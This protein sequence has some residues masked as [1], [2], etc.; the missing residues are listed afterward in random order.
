MILRRRNNN[1]ISFAVES[2]SARCGDDGQ[3]QRL[4]AF[5]RNLKDAV[6]FKVGDEDCSLGINGHRHWHTDT[7]SV[8]GQL[9]WLSVITE[10]IYLPSRCVSDQNFAIF[11]KGDTPGGVERCAELLRRF[12]EVMEFSVAALP[13]SRQPQINYGDLSIVRAD[14]SERIVH[15]VCGCRQSS[16]TNGGN[17]DHRRTTKSK[18]INLRTNTSQKR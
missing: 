10:S 15:S 12:E 8:S 3:L 13:D 7:H 11:V 17:N 16:Q 18:H 1:E 2:Q 6:K 5:V 9:C 4:A 14:R